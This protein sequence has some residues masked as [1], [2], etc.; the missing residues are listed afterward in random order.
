MTVLAKAAAILDGA[1]PEDLRQMTP[2]ERARFIDTMRHWWQAALREQHPLNPKAGVLG[3][4]KTG[5]R[6]E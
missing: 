1:S 3:D 6:S 2:V 4:L 5:A